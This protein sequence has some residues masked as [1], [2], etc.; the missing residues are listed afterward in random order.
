MNAICRFVGVVVMDMDFLSIDF[1]ACPI[2][3]GNPG[4]SYLSGISRCKTNTTQVNAVKPGYKFDQHW[5]LR[6]GLPIGDQ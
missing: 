4:P 3:I 6:A 5:K 1:N 2:S